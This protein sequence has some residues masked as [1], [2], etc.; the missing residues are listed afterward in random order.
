MGDALAERLAQEQGRACL[1]FDY[2]GHGESDG[3]FGE[4]TIGLWAEQARLGYSPIVDF[5]WVYPAGAIVPIM[6]AI[7]AGPYNYQLCWFLLVV[8]ATLSPYRLRLLSKILV[9]GEFRYFGLPSPITRPPKPITRLLTS[10]IG[11]ITRFQNLSY[12]P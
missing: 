10:M 5:P 6:G 8:L 11:K 9:S 3:A 1:R 4:G 2:S 12:I 7:A